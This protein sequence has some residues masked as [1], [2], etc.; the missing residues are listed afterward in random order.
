MN[1]ASTQPNKKYP[2]YKERGIFI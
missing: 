2:D 1:Q